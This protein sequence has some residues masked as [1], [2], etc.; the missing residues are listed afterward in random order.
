MSLI[1]PF[2]LF[3]LPLNHSG[4]AAQDGS[5]KCH[6]LGE[7]HTWPFWGSQGGFSPVCSPGAAPPGNGISEKGTPEAL[8]RGYTPGISPPGPPRNGS[9][10]SHLHG[11]AFF[12]PS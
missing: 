1:L 8:L 2:L 10:L 9:S 4:G 12:E 3:T 11:F 7:G 6:G 5:I